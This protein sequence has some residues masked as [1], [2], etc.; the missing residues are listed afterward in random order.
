MKARKM[1]L[2]GLMGLAVIACSTPAGG[3][4]GVS[5][6]AKA[7]LP[8]KASVDTVSYL[9]GV[10]FGSMIKGNNFGDLNYKE[11][12]KGIVDFLKAEGSPYDEA[13]GDQFKI[14]PND[15]N[16]IINSYLEKMA[17]Y[18]VAVNTEK[19]NK[20][21]EEN[22]KKANVQET[23]SGLQYEV[24]VE[25]DMSKKA[26]SPADTVV[27]RYKGSLLDGTVFDEVGP[28]MDPIDLTLN[29]VIPGWTE[30]LQ[31]VGEGGL[32]K[33]YIPSRLGY[34]ERGTQG[35]EPNSTLVFDVE[36]VEVRP[37]TEE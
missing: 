33:L 11:M 25:G 34:G 19:E 5:K 27:V 31:L 9:L 20:F 29:R 32:I 21:F 2:V 16:S 30:G 17:A 8:S 37:Y 35:I 26:T 12:E 3:Q 23:E 15:M 13:F 18:T 24:I 10:N 1:I 4:E 22:K 28:E 6:E 7:L 14:N 36:V